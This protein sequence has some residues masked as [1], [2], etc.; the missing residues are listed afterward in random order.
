MRQQVVEGRGPVRDDLGD[1]RR[2]RDRRDRPLLRPA[3]PG[4]ASPS[5]PRQPRRRRSIARQARHR[6]LR[7]C[8]AARCA[9]WPATRCG[10]TS[11]GSSASTSIPRCDPEEWDVRGLAGWA[12]QYGLSLT[13]NQIRKADPAELLEQIIA[14][15]QKKMQTQDLAPLQQYVDPLFAKARLVRWAKEKFEVDVPLDDLATANRDEAQRV[16]ARE[17]AGRVPPARDR[18]P[19]RGGDRLR[20]AARRLERQRGLQPHRDV[21][22]PQVRPGAGPTSTSRARTRSRS[23]DE[24]R[25]VN[26]DFL[27]NGKLDGE[28][29]AALARSTGRGAAGWARQRFGACSTANPL[30]ARRRRARAVAALRATRCCA[31][32]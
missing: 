22:Q 11:S 14:A 17:D 13:Q 19:G 32:S 6:A 26:E 15:A 7:R 31:T 10:R 28:I 12:A 4:A 25:A 20:A 18:V 30:D 23:S 8:S 1:D 5:G 16:I 24:L 21:G 29:D 9:T 3:V 2:D 27:N